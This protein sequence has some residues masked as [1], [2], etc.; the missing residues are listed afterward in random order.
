MQII[1]IVV[2]RF[3]R[4][5]NG[6]FTVLKNSLS[7]ILL[8]TV[9]K[10]YILSK[11]LLF[12]VRKLYILSKTFA[13]YCP[14]TIYTIQNLLFTVRKLYILSKT[15]YL[16]SKNYIYYPNMDNYYPKP[17][18]YYPNGLEYLGTYNSQCRKLE[19]GIRNGQYK[20]IKSVTYSRKS[21]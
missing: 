1:E 12:T 2:R 11:I 18:F 17:I 5:E 13:I 9:R 21:K 4:S 8:F 20:G 16:L 7:K 10:L 14:E 6:V 19:M 15:C 3:L